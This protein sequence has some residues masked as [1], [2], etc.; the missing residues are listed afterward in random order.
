M[1]ALS[2]SLTA[3]KGTMGYI[4]PELFYKNLGGVS[5]NKKTADVYSFGML[6][7][8]M[9]SRRKN[10]NVIATHSSQIYFPSWVYDQYHG[11]NDMEMV[12]EEERHII[13]KMVYSTKA[14]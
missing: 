12:L 6:L 2:I 3:G 7:M 9:A 5:H 1:I 14:R 10:L 11:G 13:K 8:E 4:A